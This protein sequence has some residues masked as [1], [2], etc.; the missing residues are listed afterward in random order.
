MKYR[1][2]VHPDAMDDIRRNARWWAEHHSQE[3][4]LAWYDHALA[5]LYELEHLPERHAVS[6]ENDDFPYEIRDL[7]FGLGSRPSCRAIF[8]IQYKTVHVLTV[9]RGAQNTLRPEDVPFSPDD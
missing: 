3:Q 4:A 1:V 5:S 9:Q 7:L 2:V 8:T 6:R